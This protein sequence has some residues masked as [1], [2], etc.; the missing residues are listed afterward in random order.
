[1]RPVRQ[2]WPDLAPEEVPG[3]LGEGFFRPLPARRIL[4][5]PGLK[6]GHVFGIKFGNLFGTAEAA[7]ED[8]FSFTGGSPA[9]R[10]WALSWPPF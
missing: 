4:S 7:P 5:L 2:L 8:S 1:M 9:G 10:F 6:F 3:G